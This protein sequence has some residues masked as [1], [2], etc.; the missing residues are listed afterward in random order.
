MMDAFQFRKLNSAPAAT[1]T[2]AV[3][4]AG[5]ARDPGNLVAS[6]TDLAGASLAN[7]LTPAL[8]G[9]VDS[10][11]FRTPDV[12]RVDIWWEQGGIYLARDTTVG[13]RQAPFEPAG[14]VAAHAGSVQHGTT[15][16]EQSNLATAYNHSQSAHAPA[17]AEANYAAATQAQAED[18]AGTTLLSWTA[19]RIWQAIAKWGNTAASVFKGIMGGGYKETLYTA[20]TSGNVTIDLANGNVQRFILGGNHQF[21]FPADPGAYA[22]SFVLIIE[23]AT[24]TPTWAASPVIEW[25]TDGGAAPTLVTTA[26]LVNVLT[27][28]WD[29][30]DSRWLGFLAGKETA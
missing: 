22:Q 20:T 3:Y 16:T 9:G 24:Y 28:I 6:L 1:D 12:T 10:W 7:P 21:T 15:P 29:D 25:L 4:V 17:N 5:A 27:F 23:C 11:G 18:S 2:I 30:V 8:A 14:A 26:N 19:Q 13:G